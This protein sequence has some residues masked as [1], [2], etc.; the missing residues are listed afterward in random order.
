MTNNGAG[1]LYRIYTTTQR[2]NVGFNLALI[3]RDFQSPTREFS[4]YALY[5]QLFSPMGAKRA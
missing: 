2:Y 3:E 1:D 4:R 5:A